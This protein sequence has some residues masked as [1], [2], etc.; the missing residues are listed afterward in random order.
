MKE[1]DHPNIVKLVK[2]Y[3]DKDNF[4]LVMEYMEGGE[5]SEFFLLNSLQLFDKIIKKEFFDETS[6]H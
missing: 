4:S 6:A 2:S 5:V 1:I 3:E